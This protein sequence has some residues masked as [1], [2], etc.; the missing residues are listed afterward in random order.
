MFLSLHY[1]FIVHGI[2]KVRNNGSK[3]YQKNLKMFRWLYQDRQGHESSDVLKVYNTHAI[4][5]IAVFIIM[6]LMLLGW[7][8]M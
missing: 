2:Q 8:Y 3:N 6:K 1:S 5:W 4:A 7:I